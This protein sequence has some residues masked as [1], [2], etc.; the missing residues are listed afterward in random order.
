MTTATKAH[1]NAALYWKVGLF[2][3]V[4]TAVEIGVSYVDALGSLRV[5]LLLLLG[6][7]KFLTVVAVYMH[8]RYEL[9]A[10]RRLF[11]VGLIGALII[12]AVVLATFRAF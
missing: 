4:V 1:P 5:P 3:A 12:F 11:F 9:T 7:A 2:L 6:A 10:Y 8:L